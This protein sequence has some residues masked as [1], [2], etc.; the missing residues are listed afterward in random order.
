VGAGLKL[1]SDRGGEI[2]QI[3]FRWR[4]SGA[5]IHG[6]GHGKA[7]WELENRIS[8]FGTRHLSK[9]L[10][11]PSFTIIKRDQFMELRLIHIAQLLFKHH[12]N[13]QQHTCYARNHSFSEPA[14]TLT[15]LIIPQCL[16][17]IYILRRETVSIMFPVPCAAYFL[18]VFS[19]AASSSGCVGLELSLLFV[20]SLFCC[21]FPPS[22]APPC[23][24]GLLATVPDWPS[25]WFS[26][27]GDWRPWLG[28]DIVGCV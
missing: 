1:W 2:V 9:P 18:L 28:A 23:S 4:G 11:K 8:D 13:W 19:F 26:G 6:H 5:T 25:V 24:L 21:A 15:G 3:N 27:S 10:L 16:I 17:D 12:S 7:A 14:C 20:S 22:G